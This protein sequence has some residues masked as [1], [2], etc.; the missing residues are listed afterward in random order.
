MT[1]PRQWAGHYAPS[2]LPCVVP[3]NRGAVPSFYASN[4]VCG[5][6]SFVTSPITLVACMPSAL[7]GGPCCGSNVQHGVIFRMIS[8]R[9]PQ[10]RYP[11]WGTQSIRPVHD[12]TALQGVSCHATYGAFTTINPQLPSVVG[13]PW[14]ACLIIS[15]DNVRCSHT[16]LWGYRRFRSSW[17]AL[18]QIIVLVNNA[19]IA[20]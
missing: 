19:G 11:T 6:P 5:D 20:G 8:T 18:K 14:S 4:E 15:V 2:S 13:D 12:R 3:S 17:S 7:E 16:C 1:I 10:E 9:C